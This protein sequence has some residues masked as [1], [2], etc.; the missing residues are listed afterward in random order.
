MRGVS[1]ERRRHHERVPEDFLIVRNPDVA[2]R[3][4]YLLR[5]PLPGRPI[6]L[7]ARETWPRTNKVFCHRAE[8]WPA[9]PEVVERVAVRSCER[10]GAA[11]D[12]V[13]ERGRENRSQFVLTFARGREAIF[14]QTARTTRQARPRVR[15][16]T[17]R[18][19]G[20]DR[21]TVLVDIRERYP[22]RFAAQ[23]V[24][25]GRRP[26]S[27]GDY[28]VE[29]DG[30][31]VAA[32][33]RK[34]AGDLVTSLTTGRLRFALAELAALPR[35]AVV[36]E[37]RW[38]AV[39]VHQYVRASVVAD[40][41]AEL[42]VRWPSVPVVFLETRPLAEEWTYRWLAAALT[43]AEDDELA[44]DRF[45]ELTTAGDL[46]LREPT[47]ADVRAWALAT[48]LPVSDR[49][50]LRSQVWAAWREAHDA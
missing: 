18:A 42:A 11:I 1:A 8:E 6:L 2:S 26:L 40:G 38:S 50:R 44:V 31:I 27:V 15:L 24:D 32:V 20:H 4:P 10:R 13:L 37:D 46:P 16:P 19:G 21:F 41:L 43:A 47:T 25:V 7:K 12:L 22:Y 17:A 23:Q 48:G 29:H 39:L 30:R 9:E 28:A 36:V 34:G 35:A 33:E 49:G 5:L 3:L 45:A 14:W